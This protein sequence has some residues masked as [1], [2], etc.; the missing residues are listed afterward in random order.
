MTRPQSS[1]SIAESALE[2]LWLHPA[3]IQTGSLLNIMICRQIAVRE[4]GAPS[5]AAYPSGY[6]AVFSGGL[7]AKY[8]PAVPDNALRYASLIVPQ[9][10]AIAVH[11]PVLSTVSKG[12]RTVFIAFVPDLYTSK[13]EGKTQRNWCIWRARPREYKSG[14]ESIL[15]HGPTNV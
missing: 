9:F 14:R 8:A 3:C 1:G 12:G 4:S 6:A 5:H 7:S 2:I 13:D 11:I 10:Y 15:I